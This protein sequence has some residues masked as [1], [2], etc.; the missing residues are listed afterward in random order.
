MSD[1]LEDR[2]EKNPDGTPKLIPDTVDEIRIFGFNILGCK[3]EEDIDNLFFHEMVEGSPEGWV[4][5]KFHP[6]GED[7]PI[8]KSWYSNPDIRRMLEAPPI[9][10]LQIYLGRDAGKVFTVKDK[11]GIIMGGFILTGMGD[12]GAPTTGIV[13]A[14]IVDPDYQNA[15]VGKKMIPLI[16]AEAK[17]LGYTSLCASVFVDNPAAI[18]LIQEAGLREGRWFAGNLE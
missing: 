6:E 11:M 3:D 16:K 9:E 2:L 12:E 10:N 17:R 7:F 18:R 8:W 4:A 13:T 15:G 14:L 5:S 1:P